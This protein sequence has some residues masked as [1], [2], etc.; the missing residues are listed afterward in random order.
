MKGAFDGHC[1]RTACQQP[2]ARWWN[3]GTRKYYCQ[4]CALRINRVCAEIICVPC[5]ESGEPDL[6]YT[7]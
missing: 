3:K 4:T 2:P 7:G 5:D 1:N 6:T